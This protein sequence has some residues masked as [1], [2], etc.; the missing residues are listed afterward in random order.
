VLIVA[1][2]SRWLLERF[3][4]SGDIRPA[5]FLFTLGLTLGRLGAATQL[6]DVG[7]RMLGIGLSLAAIGHLWWSKSLSPTD[8]TERP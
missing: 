1:M 3:A 8:A 2:G 6:D 7:G 4:R 5:A